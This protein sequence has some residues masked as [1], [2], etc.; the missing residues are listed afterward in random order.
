MLAQLVSL[1]LPKNV[2]HYFELIGVTEQEISGGEK[3][4]LCL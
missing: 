3:G 1:F 2:L 4:V